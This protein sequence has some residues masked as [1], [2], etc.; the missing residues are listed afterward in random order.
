MRLAELNALDADAA[1]AAFLRCCGSSRWARQM[2]AA[3]PFADATAMAQAADRIGSALEAADWLEAFAAHPKIGAGRTGSAGGAGRAGRSGGAGAAGGEDWSAQEQASVALAA[4]E[5]LRRLADANRE[6]RG[7]LRIYLHR[8]RHRQDHG[9]DACPSSSAAC[10][11]MRATSSHSPRRSSGRSRGLR[12]IKLL[13]QEPGTTCMITTH[14]LDIARGQPAEGIAV[15]LELRQTSEWAPIGRGTT[16]EKGRVNTLADGP[17]RPGLT[18][19]RSTSV[20]IDRSRGLT[21][22]FFPEVTITFNVRDPD[23]HYHL[24]LLLSPFG[25]TTYRGT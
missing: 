12:L 23:E 25:Y 4:D 13:E 10:G 24:P 18:G 14:V 5:T 1:A 22:S 20:A 8:L 7:P 6:L 9:G 19:S 3:R 21:A 15:I 16:D 17:I 11:M 2:S